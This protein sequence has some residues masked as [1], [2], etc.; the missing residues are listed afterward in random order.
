MP[1]SLPTSTPPSPIPIS[2]REINAD[3]LMPLTSFV[4]L[5][6][7]A[8]P[9]VFKDLIGN[10][11]VNALYADQDATTFTYEGLVVT[12]QQYEEIGIINLNGTVC[13]TPTGAAWLLDL[14]AKGLIP[15]S[16]KSPGTAPEE[17][18]AYSRSHNDLVQR[19]TVARA[20]RTAAAAAYEAKISNPNSIQESEFTYSLLNDLSFRIRPEGGPCEFEVGGLSVSKHVTTLRSNSGKSADSTV[21]F[22]WRSGGELRSVDKESQ[23]AGNRANDEQRNWGLP[24]SGF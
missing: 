6:P 10:D 9:R 4:A 14:Y 7:G 12:F 15:M 11:F 8:K 17:A 22:Q 16:R 2:P 19:T 24:P 3:L 18:V 5:L 23:F 21:T 1:D 13:V 20:A